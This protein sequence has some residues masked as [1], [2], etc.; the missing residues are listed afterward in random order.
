M[1]WTDRLFRRNASKRQNIDAP[2][3]EQNK[4]NVIVADKNVIDIST[5]YTNR[6][7]TFSGCL[8]GFDYD[9]ILM[10]KQNYPNMILLFR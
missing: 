4:A 1:G 10:N 9:K 5:A 6:N 7:I 2:V 8:K 3:Q